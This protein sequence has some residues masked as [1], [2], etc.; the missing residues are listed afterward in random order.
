MKPSNYEELERYARSYQFKQIMR[1][2]LGC[3][4]GN[5]GSEE[6]V[7]YHHVVPL[8]LG[9][10]NELTN[11]V[12]LCHRCHR[13]AHCGRHTSHYA[14]KNEGGRPPKIPDE[15]AFKALDLLL[16]GQIG[17]R[18]CKQLM[19]LADRTEPKQTSQY[20][21]WCKDRGIKSFRTFLD[22]TATLRPY[23]LHDGYVVGHYVDANG[24]K[25]SIRFKDTGINDVTYRFGNVKGQPEMTLYE[26]WESSYA[27]K[28]PAN[29]YSSEISSEAFLK[30][31][32]AM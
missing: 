16:D 8:F 19:G 27:P 23:A 24:N 21:R 4:C 14:E 18:K 28:R 12:P 5:C 6:N 15:D 25:H 31:L 17:N 1:K 29:E 26:L 11:I 9:G 22:V 2:E 20:K 30:G 3:K 10:T 13:A 7:E 32:K